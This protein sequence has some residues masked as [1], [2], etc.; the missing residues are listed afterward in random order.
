MK[1]N[2]KSDSRIV[3]D[4]YMEIEGRFQVLNQE[5]EVVEGI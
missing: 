1:E 3:F 5:T 4:F 2:L